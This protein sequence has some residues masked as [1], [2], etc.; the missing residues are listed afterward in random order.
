MND[1]MFVLI[2]K[3]ILLD[4]MIGRDIWNYMIQA[5]NSNVQDNSSTEDHGVVTRNSQEKML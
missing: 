1:L 2:V 3:K 5:R 4:N